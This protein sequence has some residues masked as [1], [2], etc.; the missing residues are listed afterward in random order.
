MPKKRA[1]RVVDERALKIAA[2]INEAVTARVGPSATFEERENVAAVVA[3][4][5]FAE[6]RKSGDLGPKAGS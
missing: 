1:V 4:E 2:L 3:A 5:V 6:L